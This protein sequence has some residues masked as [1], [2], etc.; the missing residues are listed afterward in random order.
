M[1][2]LTEFLNSGKSVED[3]VAYYTMT[4]EFNTKSEART[5]IKEFMESNELVAVKKVTKADQLKS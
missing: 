4:G 1:K 2:D 3:C 5:A